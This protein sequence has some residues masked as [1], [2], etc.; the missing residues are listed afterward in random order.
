MILEHIKKLD[1][2]IIIPAVVLSIIGLFSIYSYCQGRED[3]LN[4][5]K[6]ILFLV[7]GIII[8]LLLSFFDWREFRENSYLIMALYFF[9]LISLLG[10]LL[11][12]PVTRG[13]KGWYKFGEFSFDPVEF[14]KVILIIL[15]AKYFSM[16]HVEMYRLTHIILSGF[17]V[18]LPAILVF[19]RPDLG[20]AIILILLWIGILIVS[21]IKIRHFIILSLCGLMIMA[22]G[23][24]FLLKDYQK[25]RV[26]TFISPA[27]PQ[28]MNWSQNQSKIAIGSGRL[29]GQ[30]F[31]KGSQTKYGFLSEPH[32]DFIFSVIAEEFGLLGVGFVFLMFGV[33]IYRIMKIAISAYSNFPRLF[34][35]GF[36]IVLISQIFIHTGMNLGILPVIGISLPFVSYGGSGLIASYFSLGILLSIKRR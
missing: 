11:F 28:G 1:Y 8:M 19:L 4:F 13:I 7:L 10:L 22:A 17:Y 33:L 36:I 6:Q 34:A 21:G 31:A 25:E 18:M 3:F 5:K 35:T 9:S 27:D 12:A 16:R 14:T 30:G 23:W 32:T 24:M 15:L 26:I 2:W 29:F 20:S